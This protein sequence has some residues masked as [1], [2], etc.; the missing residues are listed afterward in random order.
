MDDDLKWIIGI[1]VG[2]AVTSG[3]VLIKSFRGLHL[4]IAENHGHMNTRIDMIK[5]DYVRRDDL[6]RDMDRIDT[7][8]HDLRQ[9]IR[10][11]NAQVLS[12]IAAIA[13]KP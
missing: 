6:T 1:M 10:E 5:D 8:L 7:S 3:G 4:K 2:I 13:S 9:E 11:N 12:A